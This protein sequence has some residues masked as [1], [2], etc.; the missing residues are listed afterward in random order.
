MNLSAHFIDRPRLATVIAVVMAIAGALALFQ[1]P[2][3]QFPQITPPEVQVTASYP[4]ANASVLE[5]SVGAP[6]EDQVNGVEDM[7]YMSSSSTNN[8]TYSLTVTFAVGT[9]PALAQ[10][11][12]QNRVAL[13]TP[14]L[15]ASVTQT[16]VSV[17]ARSSSMLMGVAIYSPEGTRDEIFISN[18]AANNIR[19]AIARV[20]GVGEAGI[21]GPSY[22]MRIWMN[23]D[24]MQ[25]LGLTATDLTSA[26]Q[27]QNAQA[28]AG[29]LGSPPATSGQQLQLTIMAQGRLATEEDFSNIIVRTNTEGALVRLRDVARV[30]LGAQSYDT[31]STFNGQPSATVVV[32][33]SAEANALAVSRAVLSELDRLSRQFPED[34]AYAIVFDTTAF[35]TETIKEIAITLAIT[36][37]LVVAVTYFFLQDWRATVIPTLT[38][39]VSLIG[40][41]AVLYLLDYSANTITL[42]AVI[43]AISL[44][45][46]DAIIVVEN[47]KR[48]MAEE[49]LNVHDATRRTMS[50]VTGP[51][52][53]TTLVLAALFVPIAFVAGITGQLYRQFSVTILITITFS[54]INALTLS[55][56]LCV[57]MLRSP[58]EQRSGI[59]GTFNR[60]LDFSRN[61]YVAMLDRMSRQLW[62]ASVILLAILGGVYGLFRALPTGFVPSEDQGYLFINVQLPNAASLERTQQA[63][64]TVSR[65]LQRTPGVA[66]SVGIAGN[67]MVGG[68]GSN[69]GMVI[70]A[71]KPWGERRSA[72]ESIDAIMNR[73]RAEFG[74]IPTASVV[75]FNP[76]AIP[77]LGT[78]GGFD[79]R[80]QARSGQSQ[81]GIAEVMRGLIVKANQTPG[82]ASVFSTFSADV[83]QVFLNVDRRRAE[84]FGVSTAT[85][86]NAMQS[87]L[88]SSYVDDFNIFS[89][90]YQVRIQDEPQFRSRIEDI[91]RLRVRSR[92]GE[93]VP[94]QSLLSIST[95]YGPTAINRYNLFPSASINGQAATG[96]STGQALATM[97]SLAEQNLPEGFGF[98][99][100]GLALQEEQAGNQT[101]LI[102]LMGLIFTYLFL[103]GQYESW[104][105]PLAVMLSVAVAVLGALV[106]L[107]LASIDINIYAQIGLVL[108]IGLAAK[109]AILIVE[110]A[111]E[112]RDK[113]MATPEAAA[114]GTAQ[115]F[116][117]VLMTAMASILGV[118]PL[119]IATGAG[120]GSRRAIGMTV[121]GGL[122]VGTVVGLLLIPV[123]YVLVQTVR[124]QAKERF[125]RT[126]AG[127]K[128]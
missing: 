30:E 105:V 69:A 1:I 86:F 96:T 2:I 80:L 75:P 57:L 46:D 37:A 53:A 103:V 78:T 9:D 6:I 12:V 44:V 40:G 31:A 54:T 107:M 7:L 112:R 4:G 5:E 11:N 76:P 20:A 104:S 110:F 117:P 93:L 121:F 77:G 100:T 34:V 8:G 21:F 72:E 58:R 65:I 128:A 102:L 70:T 115:R 63:L 108:L 52:V 94:L 60:G 123:F 15:P 79:L 68:G 74:R 97:A 51:I 17:R 18:Y 119:V 114:A 56:A 67:S 106:G 50:Q 42:F 26:I 124:E 47:V 83:P 92:N 73:L 48:L 25:A 10:V 64:D 89:R 38:I 23:P 81:Q 98:E 109:N 125:F 87:H 127:R 43:L 45:V 71:L 29:Q 59:F 116:R 32:Y 99:W 39:P 91:Q 28:S 90:V 27:A 36:F 41:F 16:G 101:A 66:N 85:I 22:S 35:I 126:R 84:L 24:R 14:R 88:G 33:Q 3:A 120:A 95:S 13:A 113:G 19:D 118:I 82:L 55:P 49:R 111:K 122:L 62:I 61:W